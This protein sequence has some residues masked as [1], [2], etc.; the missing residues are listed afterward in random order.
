[1]PVSDPPLQF[2]LKAASRC[3]LNCSYCYVYNKG[4]ASWRGRPAFMSDAVLDDVILRVRR[5]AERSGQPLVRFTFHGGEPLLA[6]P[7]RLRGWCRRLRRELADV[8]HV[9]FSLQTNGT[10]IDARWAD[11]FAELDVDVGVSIDGPRAIHDAARVDHRGRPSY[12][13]VV[14]GI[15]ALRAAGRPV[16]LL[17]V[18]PLGAEPLAI[19]EHA[20]GLGPNSV[21]YLLPD[22]THDTIGPVREQHGPHPC[23]DFLIPIFDAWH[24]TGDPTMRISLLW[25]VSRTVL[26]GDSRLDLIGNRPF[27]FVFVEADGDIEG[28]DVLRVCTDG[29]Q[30]TGLNV[31]RDDFWQVAERSPLHRAAMRD[32]V[33]LPS[34]CRGCR[35][36]HTCAGGYLPHRHSAARGFD[37]PS[38][39]CTDLLML[40][41]HVRARLGVSVE[42]TEERRTALGLKEA[43]PC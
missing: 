8:A 1:M 18:V 11:L 13:L 28:L 21:S 20:L 19:H 15:D 16:N 33:P 35:E 14:R 26:G 24:D 43:A 3:N 5:Y 29:A 9:A 6:G 30:Q 42:E 32:G 38:V 27:H 12:D 25:S 31:A 10:L 37:N 34:G 41:D 2:V 40:F 17:S 39:W 7:E 36:E 22:F 23:A 4:D